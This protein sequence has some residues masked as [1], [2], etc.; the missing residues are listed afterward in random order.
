MKLNTTAHKQE[1]MRFRK[2][3]GFRQGPVIT[4]KSVL[5]ERQSRKSSQCN[6]VGAKGESLI[7]KAALKQRPPLRLQKD[8]HLCPICT[9]PKP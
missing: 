1:Q 5:V 6:Q 3:T 2:V 7:L 9:G 8:R 4:L